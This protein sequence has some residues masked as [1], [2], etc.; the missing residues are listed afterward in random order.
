[1][2]AAFALALLASALA[3]SFVETPQ[4]LYSRGTDQFAARKFDDA[5]SSFQ[6]AIDID[7]LYAPA[8]R[9]LG[10]ANLALKDYQGAYRAWLKAVDLDPKDEKS[11]YCLGRL[12][13]D[14]NL[15]NEAAAWLRQALELDANDF[16][17]MTYLGLSAEALDFGDTASQLYRKAIAVSEAQRRPYSWAFLSLANYYKKHDEQSKA[18]AVLER[19]AQQCPEAHELATLGGMLAASGDSKRAE[20]LLRQAISL[21]PTLSQAHYR[22]GLLLK[23]SG[24]PEE[25]AEE[26]VKF[27]QAKA[28]EDKAPKVTALRKSGSTS[29]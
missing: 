23:S 11:K 15:P 25:A 3:Q 5:K 20:E 14:A 27:Q 21:D 28:E 13:Y 26:M 10:L 18:V 29:P 16:E 9:G 4:S 12:F 6:R 17:A 24:R 1:M 19:G 7:H 22:L 8:Y 2:P